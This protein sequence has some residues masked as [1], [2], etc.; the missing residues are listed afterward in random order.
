MNANLRI[1][2]DKNFLNCNKLCF[3]FFEMREG[4]HPSAR[5]LMN[6]I[7]EN[8]KSNEKNVN[9]FSINNKNSKKDSYKIEITTC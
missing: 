7:N 3:N 4:D 5:N 8:I 9:Y 1:K 6:Q 2:N